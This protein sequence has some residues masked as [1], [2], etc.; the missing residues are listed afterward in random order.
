MAQY[1]IDILGENL[2]IEPLKTHPCK[3]HCPLPSPN[4]LKYKILIKNKKLHRNSSEKLNNQNGPTVYQ[5]PVPTLIPNNGTQNGDIDSNSSSSELTLPEKPTD[6]LNHDTKISGQATVPLNDSRIFES[7][8]SGGIVIDSELPDEPAFLDE[9]NRNNIHVPNDTAYVEPEATKAMSDLVNYVVPVPLKT[10]EQAKMRHR[11][12]EMSSFNEDR[13][14][15]LVHECSR[16]FL[17]YNTRQISRIYPRGPRIHSSNYNPYIFWTV[18]CQMCALN[19]QTLGT[20]KTS[21]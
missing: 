11:N 5:K 18:G 13:G 8:S 12:Y 1:F 20:N 16:E 2:L 21:M 3:E 9:I 10:F 19:Y 17:D 15:S 4:D 6:K 14:L 7:N